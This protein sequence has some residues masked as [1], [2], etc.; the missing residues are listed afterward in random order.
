M[1]QRLFTLPWIEQN[2]DHIRED[3]CLRGD[4]GPKYKEGNFS[5]CKILS[6]YSCSSMNKIKRKT[7][8]DFS[9]SFAKVDCKSV[10][11]KLFLEIKSKSIKHY[12]TGKSSWVQIIRWVC[13]M[14]TM[15]N[16][17]NMKHYKPCSSSLVENFKISFPF[18]E[19]RANWLTLFV[20]RWN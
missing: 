9:F 2:R 19:V 4:S 15:L 6:I 12:A 11:T 20:F 13:T 14:T 10:R 16:V 17:P 18:K 1:V 5:V 3:H 7:T 8:I